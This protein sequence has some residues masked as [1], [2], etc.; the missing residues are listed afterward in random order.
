MFNKKNLIKNKCIFII[1]IKHFFENG[2][3]TACKKITSF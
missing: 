3:L 2:L 1:F